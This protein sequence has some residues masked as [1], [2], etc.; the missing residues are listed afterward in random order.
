MRR[1]ALL[2]AVAVVGST[3]RQLLSDARHARFAEWGREAV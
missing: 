2:A 1:F 3:F